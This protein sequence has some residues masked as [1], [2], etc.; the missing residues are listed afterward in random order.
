[1]SFFLF[2]HYKIF[3]LKKISAIIWHKKVELYPP[4]TQLDMEFNK[5]IKPYIRNYIINVVNLIPINKPNI[6]T[7]PIQARIYLR[8]LLTLL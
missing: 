8:Y 2:L 7:K 5:Q 1:M 3:Y 4:C 6:N